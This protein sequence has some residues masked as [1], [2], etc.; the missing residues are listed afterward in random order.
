MSMKKTDLE[1]NKAMKIAGQMRAAGTADR[2]AQG[3]AA[4]GERREQ[5]RRD[6]FDARR[7][8]EIRVGKA[9][10]CRDRARHAPARM[11]PRLEHTQAHVVDQHRALLRAVERGDS[12]RAERA[13]KDHLL[14]L[15]DVL[16]MAEE[17]G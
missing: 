15:R 1:K 6:V 17:R 7:V 9:G 10:Q 12:A 3:A 4:A 13:M 14:Y 16:R 11:N 5:R 2:W 8:R